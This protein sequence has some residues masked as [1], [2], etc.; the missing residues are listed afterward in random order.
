MS[1]QWEGGGQCYPAHSYTVPLHLGVP[2]QLLG[3]LDK[4]VEWG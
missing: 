1:A 3:D 4:Y 2:T